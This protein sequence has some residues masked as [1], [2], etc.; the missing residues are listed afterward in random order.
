MSYQ[1]YK[2]QANVHWPVQDMDSRSGLVPVYVVE[3]YR[4]SV[5]DHNEKDGGC[6]FYQKAL[7]SEIV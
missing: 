3:M 6:T 5:I 1:K 2:F 7:Q 4:Y